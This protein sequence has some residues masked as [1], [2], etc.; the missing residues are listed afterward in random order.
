[1]H[2]S[3]GE[4]LAA[5]RD[6]FTDAGVSLVVGRQ[7]PAGRLDLVLHS[8]SLGA[9]AIRASEVLGSVIKDD[10][11]DVLAGLGRGGHGVFLRLPQTCDSLKSEP[12]SQTGDPTACRRNTCGACCPMEW[13]RSLGPRGS[14]LR[15]CSWSH[16]SVQFLPAG[17]GLP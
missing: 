6:E 13:P 10:G 7:G 5:G 1:M 9:E 14:C 12:A 16:A 15:V 11:R 8:I 3:D 17:Q 4:D 2:W